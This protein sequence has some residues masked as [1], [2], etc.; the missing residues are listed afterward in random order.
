[1]WIN[2]YI[3]P[4]IPMFDEG[5]TKEYFFYF[6]DDILWQYGSWQAGMPLVDFS[7]P[8]AHVLGSSLHRFLNS[9]G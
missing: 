3:E 1:V 6:G 2:S 7:K 4:D 9:D 8:D 5:A